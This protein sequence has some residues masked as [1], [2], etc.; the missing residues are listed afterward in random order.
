VHILSEGSSAMT[1]GTVERISIEAAKLAPLILFLGSL[2]D[3]SST[4]VPSSAIHDE[5]PVGSRA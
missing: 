1:L 4:H 3:H 5:A 2:C